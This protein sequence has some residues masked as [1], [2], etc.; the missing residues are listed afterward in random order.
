MTRQIRHIIAFSVIALASYSIIQYFF[1]EKE[2]NK[3]EPFTK[4]YAIENL[5][6]KI[7]DDSGKFTAM[8]KSPGLVRYTD[9][10][11]IY[12]EKPLF[13]LF[14]KGKKNWQVNAQKAEYD[15][16]G[17]KIKF[18]DKVKARSLNTQPVSLLAAKNLSL[19]LKKKKANTSSGILFKQGQLTMQG[20]IA[21]F[22]LKNEILEVNNNVNAIYKAKK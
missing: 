22:D 16:S 15:V 2:I 10:P 7:T 20:Q 4:G 6:M 17:E 14:D 5:E 8:F 13:W 12:V 3:D 18:I 19:D 21:Q 1:D 9:N 11:L